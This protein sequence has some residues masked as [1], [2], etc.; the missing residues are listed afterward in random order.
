LR[1]NQNLIL[2]LLLGLSWNLMRPNSN[3]T[4]YL[5]FFYNNVRAEPFICYVNSIQNSVE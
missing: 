4:R 3:A 2:A 1:Y 5:N